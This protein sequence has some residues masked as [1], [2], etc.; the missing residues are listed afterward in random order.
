[1]KEYKINLEL[2]RGESGMNDFE[3]M[4][5]L[6]PFDEEEKVQEVEDE[7]EKFIVDHGGKIEKTDSWGKKRLAYDDYD[8]GYYYLITFKMSDDGVKELHEYMKSEQ[9]RESV[10]SHMIIRG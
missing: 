1:M 6:P 8:Y 2:L 4:F 7:I 3:V 10:L 5:I 9:D